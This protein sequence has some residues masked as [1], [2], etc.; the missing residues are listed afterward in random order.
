MVFTKAVRERGSLS[1]YMIQCLPFGPPRVG[2]TCL[3]HCLLDKAPPGIPSTLNELGTGSEST[4]VLTGRR[5]IQVKITCQGSV[6]VFVAD[7]EDSKW[8]EVT[9]LPEE[10]AIYLKTIEEE[11]KP[12]SAYSVNIPDTEHASDSIP[13]DDSKEMEQLHVSD[14]IKE[15]VSSVINIE[16][17]SHD[18]GE[19]VGSAVELSVASVS[20]TTAD[21]TA[22]ATATM[23]DDTLVK[24]ITK[25]VSGCNIDMSKVQ[26]LLDKSMTIFYTDT[27]GQPE[28]H[29][30][31]PAL[32]AGPTIFLLVFNLFE[33]LDSSYRVRYES[34]SNEYEVYDS[35]FSV[36]EVLMQCFSS[37]AS[38]HDAQSHEISKQQSSAYKYV[39]LSPPPTKVLAVG[40]H[41]DLVSSDDVLKVDKELKIVLGNKDIV[42]YFST[43]ELI[44]PVAN[45]KPNAGSKVREVIDRVV[46]RKI[47]GESPYRIEMP[48]H[49]LGLELYLRQKNSSTVTLAECSELAKKFNI[50]EEELASCL[51]FLHY[52]TGTIRYY[53]SVDELKNI[54]ITEPSIIFVAV[55]EFIT[56]TFSLKYAPPTLI[57]KFKSLGL[58]SIGEVESMFN[59]HKERLQISFR[60]F[61]ALLSHLNILV[62]SYDEMFDFF[63]PCALAHAPESEG[64]RA[65]PTMNDMLLILFNEGF[66]PKGIF[67]GLLGY[68]IKK[69]WEILYDDD[70]QPHLY[71]D[72]AMLSFFHEEC[73]YSIDCVITAT[74]TYLEFNFE[75][76]FEHTNVLCPYVQQIIR[77]SMQD[78][79]DKLH[80]GNIWSFGVICK[81]QNCKSAD[82]HFARVDEMKKEA[83][84]I[85]TRR[86]YLIKDKDCYWFSSK[87]QLNLMNL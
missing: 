66:V 73:D 77:C 57:G 58:F 56:S 8:N 33:H 9:T 17:D 63:L 69:E 36:R 74:A 28:F 5:M 84:C 20:T 61:T 44:I 72:K 37:I 13:S 31:L 18:L 38:Y 3:Y 34:S 75:N 40:T 39:K 80:Y 64:K 26:A 15:D 54:V 29:E 86:K 68:L 42:E 23:L 32:V 67:C 10:I 11:C 4:N 24:E 47:Q 62:P 22:T 1:F 79:C 43:N 25:H 12:Q 45:Y 82:L 16:P 59:V 35:L 6:K 52:K 60:Q 83:Q 30:V 14:S 55:T 71:R 7:R 85:K 87:F 49:W 76:H 46:K 81:H 21:T 51:W 19:H 50:E 41:E 53:G 27:G 48:V 70:M 78:V 2:K 65:T